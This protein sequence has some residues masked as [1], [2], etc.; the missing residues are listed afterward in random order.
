LEQDFTWF[1]LKTFGISVHVK[2]TFF[3][4]FLGSVDVVDC[5][6][7]QARKLQLFSKPRRIKE[8]RINTRESNLRE[9]LNEK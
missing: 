7:K 4:V 8:L 3:F 2:I 1:K 5:K 6:I 9:F